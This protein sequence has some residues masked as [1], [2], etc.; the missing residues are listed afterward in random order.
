[1]LTSNYRYDVIYDPLNDT[2]LTV[3]NNEYLDLSI[4][5]NYPKFRNAIRYVEFKALSYLLFI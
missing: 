5:E 3:N 1:M 4:E 2:W